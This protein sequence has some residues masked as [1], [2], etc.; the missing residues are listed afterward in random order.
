MLFCDYK[1]DQKA[2]ITSLIRDFS[3][4][5]Y[6]ETPSLWQWLYADNPCAESSKQLG[7]TIK[8][9]E[10]VVG[11]NGLMPV[12]IQY[13]GKMLSGAW[14]FDTIL[15]PACRG[16]GYGKKLAIAVKESN[17]LVLGLGISEIQAAIMRKIGYSINSDVQQ[18]FFCNKITSFRSLAKYCL[19]MIKRLRYF[20]LTDKI[21]S[22]LS[23]EVISSTAFK[24]H[25][26]PEAVDAL[27]DQVHQGY[28]NI[29]VRNYRYLNWKYAENPANP[30]QFIL[31]RHEGKLRA[32]GDRKSV[33]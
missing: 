26:T 24:E 31:V 13:K 9:G 18:L 12:E 15:S 10:E 17:P 4:P 7:I 28:R 33:V 19:Q 5:K 27:W 14:S 29:V 1:D 8:E 11:F 25:L 16:K 32:L 21:P 23:I 2:D 20:T 6:Q 3:H 22:D 30:H